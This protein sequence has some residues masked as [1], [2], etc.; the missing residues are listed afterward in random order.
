MFY[1]IALRD[2]D[3]SKIQFIIQESAE[4]FSGV[5]SQIFIVKFVFPRTEPNVKISIKL[6]EQF[7][8]QI[9]LRFK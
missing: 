8:H 7:S 6:I 5:L 1:K 3:K 2:L 4:N 9:Y